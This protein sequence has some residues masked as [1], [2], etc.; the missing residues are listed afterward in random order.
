MTDSIDEQMRGMGE[1]DDDL[2]PDGWPR[3]SLFAPGAITYHGGGWWSMPS[4]GSRGSVRFSG[5]YDC[6][7]ICG[8]HLAS[9]CAGCNV[10]TDCDG[11]YCYED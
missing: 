7:P 2:M 11:C 4:T 5:E 9:K 8:C 3:Y 6:N 1:A 10:C